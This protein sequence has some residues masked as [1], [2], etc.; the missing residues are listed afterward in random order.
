MC[1]NKMVSNEKRMWGRFV[2]YI[3]LE[4]KILRRECDWVNLG[5]KVYLGD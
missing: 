1:I 5:M 2:V 4:R 3:E